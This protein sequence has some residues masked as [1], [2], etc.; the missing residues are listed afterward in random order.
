[1]T[2]PEARKAVEGKGRRDRN[3]R[4]ALALPS[5]FTPAM[6]PRSRPSPP[7]FSLRPADLPR[8]GNR[9]A[10]QHVPKSPLGVEI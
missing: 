4:A 5:R 1:M 2:L 7:R 9:A 8:P 10:G 3:R 6:S